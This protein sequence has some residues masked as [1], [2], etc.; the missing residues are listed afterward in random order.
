MVIITYRFFLPVNSCQPTFAHP[1]YWSGKGAWWSRGKLSLPGAQRKER[2]V[3]CLM[4]SRGQ[5]GSSGLTFLQSS[6]GSLTFNTRLSTARGSSWAPGHAWLFQPFPRC[7]K[8][9][10]LAPLPFNNSHQVEPCPAHPVVCDKPFFTSDR[11]EW[12]SSHYSLSFWKHWAPFIAF[13]P[14]PPCNEKMFLRTPGCGKGRC[15]L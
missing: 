15:S 4:P 6:W 7:T 8:S 3:E 1:E 12:G 10:S 5:S 9:V 14:F 11:T 13:A 2:R